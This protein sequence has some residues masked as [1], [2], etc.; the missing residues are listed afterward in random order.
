[1]TISDHER[2]ID[3]ETQGKKLLVALALLMATAD[4]AAQAFPAVSAGAAFNRRVSEGPAVSRRQYAAESSAILLFR[5]DLN[6]DARIERN[7]FVAAEREGAEE[8]FELRDIDGDGVLR[9]DEIGPD[10][11]RPERGRAGLDINIRLYRYCIQQA[12]GKPPVHEDRF[13][14]ADLNG[15]GVLTQLEFSTWLEERAHVQFARLDANQDGTLTYEEL[16]D[17]FEQGHNNRRLALACRELAS[18]T[19]L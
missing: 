10:S 4:V 9:R 13:D 5:A 6:Q 2:E 16:I 19:S 8:S 12:T 15:D 3:M 1:L 11:D 18:D 14:Q 17:G 7:E